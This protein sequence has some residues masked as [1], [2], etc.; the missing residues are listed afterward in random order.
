MNS[1]AIYLSAP[2]YR[3]VLSPTE[4]LPVSISRPFDCLQAPSPIAESGPHSELLDMTMEQLA[5]EIRSGALSSRELTRACVERI[6]A[7]DDAEH[8]NSFLLNRAE[9]VIAEAAQLDDRFAATGDVVGPLHG[10]PLGIKDVIST[11]GIRTTGGMEV[12]RH[13][14]PEQDATAVSLLKS[15]GALV[16][17]KTNLDEGCQGVTSNNPY[18][19]AVRNP[20]DSS[21][22]PGGSSGGSGAAVSAHL[23]PA[24]IGTDTGGSVRIPAAL[25]G[26]VGTQTD[27]GARRAGVACSGF[28]GAMTS[29][30][31]SLAASPTPPRYCAS[32]PLVPTHSI[33]FAT[34]TPPAGSL[35]TRIDDA[36]ARLHG[37]RL[38]VPDG[39]FAD[40]NTPDVDS[41]LNNTYKLLTDAGVELVPVTVKD[42]ELATPTGI[43]TVIPEY[44]VLVERALLNAGVTGSLASALPRLGL[45]CSGLS[46]ARSARTPTRFLRSNTPG[47]CGRTSPSFGV[48]SS[49]HS[50]A[51]MHC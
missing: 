40:D 41:V 38:G 27:S 3:R 26:V 25:C 34:T 48:G 39:Y 7:L 30:D 4:E 23:C 8:L 31:R 20:Y 12:L 35:P 28:H 51:S 17:G 32:F 9:Q 45:I 33:P 37:V 24:A 50:A 1:M 19:G 42:V 15:A 36:A 5:A 11:A 47:R 29:W 49:R 16:L 43:L 13:W 10:I 6:Q 14:I 46:A 18:F 2:E 44:V 21:R 22:I